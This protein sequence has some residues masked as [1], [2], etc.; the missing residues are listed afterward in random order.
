MASILNMAA[1]KKLAAVSRDHLDINVAFTRTI[2]PDKIGKLIVEI[3]KY[4]LYERE[5]LPMP[6]DDL[7]RH[8]EDVAQSQSAQKKTVNPFLLAKQRK[9][10]TSLQ[11]MDAIFSVAQDLIRE[12]KITKVLLLFGPTVLSP[13]ESYLIRVPQRRHGCHSCG[14]AAGFRRCMLDILEAFLRVD[15]T[16]K[17]AT[18]SKL[19]TFLLVRKEDV[20]LS[21]MDVKP[22]FVVPRKGSLTTLDLALPPCPHDILE[23]GLKVWSDTI[24]DVSAYVDEDVSQSC[25]EEFVWVQCKPVFLTVAANTFVKETPS[26][27]SPK[28]LLLS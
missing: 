14:T 26:S 27:D 12:R 20:V 9:A 18:A 3:V 15:A 5:Q 24:Q 10:I 25:P 23:D 4:V 11:G 16:R 6:Y 13:I 21:L 17:A 19:T 7:K 22:S 8:V 2:S 28:N 1:S